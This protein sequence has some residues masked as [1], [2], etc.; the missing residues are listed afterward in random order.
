M[1]KKKSI[2][3]KIPRKAWQWNKTHFR[4]DGVHTR[5]GC[6]LWY[7]ETYPAYAGGGASSQSYADFIR[8]GPRINTV[9][10]EV[11]KDISIRLSRGFH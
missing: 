3:S 5:E 7:T 8:D 11:R 2:I 10:E 6:L 9:P 1:A 4:Y